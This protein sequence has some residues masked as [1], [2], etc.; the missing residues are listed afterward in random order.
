MDLSFSVMDLIHFARRL[1]GGLYYCVH[2]QEK[3]L[4]FFEI[5]I[6]KIFDK[7]KAIQKKGKLAPSCPIKYYCIMAPRKRL[8]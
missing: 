2:V 1:R 8:R 3:H 4:I 5:A 7:T 6:D